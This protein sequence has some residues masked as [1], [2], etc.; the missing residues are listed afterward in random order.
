VQISA[1][2]TS[3]WIFTGWSDNGS[4]QSPRT[5][6]VPAG[7]ATY[8]ANFTAIQTT[9]TITVLANPSNGGTV[10][11]NGSYAVGSQVQ[12]SA[13]PNSGWSFTGWSDNEST[14]SPRT[15]TVPAG[16]ATYTADFSVQATSAL[17]YV[18]NNNNS[19]GINTIL[20]LNSAGSVVGT[21]TSD[22]FNAFYAQPVFDENGNLF[23]ANYSF[24]TLLKIAPDGT[25]SEMASGFNEPD[26]LAMDSAGNLY[27]ANWSDG[28]I[29]KVTPAGAVSMFA[30]GLGGQNQQGTYGGPNGLAF[31]GSGNLYAAASGLGNV[32]KITPAGVMNVFASGFTWPSGLAF[33]MNWNLY[34]ANQDGFSISE[35]SPAGNVSTFVSGITQPQQMA[36]DSSGNL[37][38]S[39]LLD[40]GLIS[41]VTPSGQISTFAT[42]LDWPAGLAFAPAEQQATI[43]VAANP[44]NGGT[45][46]GS[47][48]Y[49]VG[50]QVQISATPTA[51]WTFTGW[52]DGNTQ[53]PRTITVPSGGATYMA[54]FIASPPTI[55]LQP[56]NA[57]A[58]A[59]GSASF[60]VSASGTGPFSYQWQLNGTNLSLGGTG[61]I[62][63]VAGD[64]ASDFTGDGG[65]ATNAGLNLPP[66]A[67]PDAFGN[68]FVSD[69]GNN[70]IRKISPGGVITTVVGTGSAAFSGDGGPAT[71]ASLNSPGG[72]A[73]DSQGRLYIPDLDNNRIRLV[74]TNGVITTFA[75]TGAA[76][77]TGD[78]GMATNAAINYPNAVTLGPNGE[79]FIVDTGNN[80]VRVVNAQGIISTV[81][82]NG[83]AGFSGD[84]GPAT[85][86]SLHGPTAVALDAWGNLYIVDHNGN[87]RVRKVTAAGIISTVAGHG[88]AGFSGDGG[89]ATNASLY[90]PSGV[91]V[92]S[93]G[94]IFICDRWNQRIR[95]VDLNGI[96]STIAGNGM[97]AFSGDG[98][99]ATQASLNFPWGVTLDNA[100]NLYVGDCFNNRIREVLAAP[101]ATLTL[102]NIGTNA[103]GN[104]DVVV[105]SPFGSVTSSVATLTIQGSRQATITVV[106]V[107]TSGGTVSGGGTFA[108]GSQQQ[109]SATPTA[110]WTFTG[111]SD[112]NT[113]NPRTITVPSG[114]ATY[115]ADFIASPPTIVLQ[116]TNATATEG[117]SASFTVSAS[118]TGPFSYQWQLN[119]TNLALGGTGNIV[120]VAG[121]GVSGFSGDGGLATSA[122]LNMPL[123]AT[124]D[125]FG[126]VFVSD[127]PNNR[128]RKI[129]LA[130][131]ITTVV[132]TGAAAFSGDGGPATNA[133]LNN[134]VGVAVDGQGRLY[135]TDGSNNRI[136]LVETNGLIS[137]FAGNGTMAFSGDGGQATNA[138]LNLPA[139]VALGGNGEVFIVDSGNN[140]IRVVDA[141]GVISTV[142]GNGQ[143]GF[144]GD[145]G[146]ATN[147]SL[148]GPTG[149][150][151]DAW[152]N[153]YIADHNGNHR[154]RKV[155]AAGIISTVAGN[156]QAGFSGD[157]GP[158]TN[159]SLFYPSSVAVDSLGNLFICDRFN[160][161]IRE[162]EGNGIISTVAGNGN[163]SYSGDGGPA[164]QASFYY[165]WGVAL[166][167]AG[168]LYIADEYNNR[169]REVLAAPGATLTLDYVG[170]NAA[171]DYDVVVT[172]PFG[173]VTS[174]VATLTVNA[175]TPSLSFIFNAPTLVLSW[176]TNAAGFSLQA[177][178]NLSDPNG[179]GPVSGIIVIGD[180]N[181]A[182]IIPSG[183]STY[184]RLK[185]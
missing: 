66:S 180:E 4:T 6:T 26:G 37:Y 50:S 35:V 95:Q 148:H 153:L 183:T 158:A 102:N 58:T 155:T 77:F 162:V 83:I 96:I 3:G 61:N 113:Q 42:G 136:R 182:I 68:V 120:T 126:N 60:T 175:S 103:A 145:G 157:G 63:T 130:G 67:T 57:T 163:Q 140:R 84:G 49:T 179:W 144:S 43:A 133:S 152:G 2:P 72:V 81:A 28:T 78:G 88:Q 138:A 90:Y 177:T 160:Q 135:I 147:A 151:L 172:N 137:T 169:I 32:Y 62:V 129:S 74:D 30:S 9:A 184:F 19:A 54:D 142:A 123:T 185:Q 116:P 29:S 38:V 7:G 33:D 40:N 150:A 108:I 53:N 14:L 124:P 170:T 143:A 39:S 131:V 79:L 174:S 17:L 92:D 94:N 166:D 119:G 11:G 132:G 52:S 109:I 5:I 59:G 118:G 181:E 149:I 112:G 121:D 80:R 164:L 171:G 27:V 44:A 21:I 115:T 31:D 8:T 10:S 86:A 91:A 105:T 51:N 146:P 159:A 45:V 24:G 167:S 20:E 154:I 34:V 82:G 178:T 127:Q 114:G 56:T 22:L 141:Q 104:Y 176:P 173:R 89:P 122:S 46:S 65:L 168:N 25:V 111:W 18:E 134:P 106:A 70:R 36:F 117:G 15:I 128:V 125:A 100:G 101:G 98:G 110:G 23:V 12:I 64:G 75:G 139:A 85:N 1:T 87:H 97:A 107:P 13:S 71:N 99:P 48:S 41:V 16:G 165:P 93:L 69:Q 161:R 73:L 156:G 47:G 55:V 76:D